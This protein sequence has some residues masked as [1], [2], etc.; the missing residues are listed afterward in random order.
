M[1]KGAPI[2][3]RGLHWHRRHKHTLFKAK[4]RLHAVIMEKLRLAAQ[5]RFWASSK[6]MELAERK[7]KE[8]QAREK[9]LFVKKSPIKKLLEKFK[10]FQHAKT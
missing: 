10:L 3:E 2:S 7:Y 6:G 1:L 8:A 5:A 4:R 9:K